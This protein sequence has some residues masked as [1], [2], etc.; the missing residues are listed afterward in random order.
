MGGH[1][2]AKVRMNRDIKRVGECNGLDSN[3][4]LQWVRK[5]NETTNP[6]SEVKS[7]AEGPLAKTIQSTSVEWCDIR[8]AILLKHVSPI[9][10]LRQRERLMK[11]RHWKDSWLAYD[12]EFAN[13]FKEAFPDGPP[14]DQEEFILLY[15]N[16]LS[17]EA[18]VYELLKQNPHTVEEVC[19]LATE[20]Q[21]YSAMMGGNQKTHLSADTK[22]AGEI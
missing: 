11:H 14:T 18:V 17:N 9:F 13:L 3:K 6:F 2:L 4:T 22:L 15:T 7:T 8:E 10:P 5:V 21:K 12:E 16:G 19:Q 1:D 20:Q